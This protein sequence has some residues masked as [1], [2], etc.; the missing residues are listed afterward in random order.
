MRLLCKEDPKPSPIE[1]SV[2]LHALRLPQP[3]RPQTLL[4]LPFTE[5]TI[6][7]KSQ[8]RSGV[9]SLPFPA[10]RGNPSRQQQRRLPFPLPRPAPGS[11]LPRCVSRPS[12]PPQA[13]R[14]ARGPHLPAAA[15]RTC[16]LRAAAK[17]LS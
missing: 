8:T 13:G 15:P 12:A 3:H 4:P 10:P 7:S 14:G 11:S 2:P 1:L 17:A 6:F 9:A 5:P 16:H